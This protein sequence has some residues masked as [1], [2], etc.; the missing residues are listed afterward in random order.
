M[1]QFLTNDVTV[2]FLGGFAFGCAM[3]FSG[4]TSLL[5]VL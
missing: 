3:V 5:H 2:R 1:V 4:A